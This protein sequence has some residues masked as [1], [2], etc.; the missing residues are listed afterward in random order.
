MRMLIS[1]DPLSGTREYV[2]YDASEDALH[3]TQEADVTA[4]LEWNKRLYN[5]AP[6]GWGEGAVFTKMHPLMRLYLKQQGIVDPD[7]KKAF[8][9]WLNDSDNRGW[10][11]RPGRG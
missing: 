10:R 6:T 7:D 5:E 11:I 1:V 4:L 9:R 2:E 8:A 3:Y